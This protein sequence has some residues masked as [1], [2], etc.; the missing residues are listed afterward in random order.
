MASPIRILAS[1]DVV[2]NKS[3]NV[4]RIYLAPQT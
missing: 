1:L 3:A 4:T 2:V